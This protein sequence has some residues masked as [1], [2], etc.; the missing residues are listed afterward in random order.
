MDVEESR[1]LGVV[2]GTVP[3]ERVDAVRRVEGAY[4]LDVLDDRPPS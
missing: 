2:L 1:D 3:A 4:R